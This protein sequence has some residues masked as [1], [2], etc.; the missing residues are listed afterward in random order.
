MFDVIFFPL[1]LI[2]RV[3]ED[4]LG[5]STDQL[6]EIRGELTRAN[7]Q[8]QEAWR[9]FK[10]NKEAML[11][12]DRQRAYDSLQEARRQL[13]HAWAQWK[14]AKA[15][16]REQQHREWLER[17]A[18]RGVRAERHREFV[19]RVHAN[20]AKLEGNI[21]RAKDALAR[22]EAHLEH[23]REQYDDAWSE[24]FRDRCSDWIDEGETRAASI[25]ESIDKLEGWLV[26]ARAK[27][28]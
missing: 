9:L 15:L 27:L 23:L 14:G 8:L 1:V 20:I 26:E 3:L 7:E 10:D 16:A 25:R 24:G 28:D 11:H 18:R 21:E 6:E 5:A 12:D 17:E 13:D 22:Q 2:K 4:L 19:A